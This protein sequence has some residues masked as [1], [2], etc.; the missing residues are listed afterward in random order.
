MYYGL[1]KDIR[2]LNCPTEN[3]G[4]KHIYYTYTIAA[5]R[6]DELMQYLEENN[7][8]TQIQHPIPMPLQSNYKK[9]QNKKYDLTLNLA[10]KILCLP[11]QEDLADLEVKY[12]CNKIKEFYL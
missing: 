6:R 9:F 1:L 11:N 12:I 8:E 10:K 2:M 3:E 5:E 7:I 4:N